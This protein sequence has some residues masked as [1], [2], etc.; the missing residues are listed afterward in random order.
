MSINPPLSRRDFLK[1]GGLALGSLAFSPFKDLGQQPDSS[2]RNPEELHPVYTNLTSQFYLDGR[3]LGRNEISESNFVIPDFARTGIENLS[4]TGNVVVDIY[5]KPSSRDPS[6]RTYQAV[7]I[8]IP[9]SDPDA[10][11]DIFHVGNSESSD[12][13]VAFPDGRVFHDSSGR[14][15]KEYENSLLNQE[16]YT[17]TFY[18]PR[19]D[20]IYTIKQ[21]DDYP[22]RFEGE[23][24]NMTEPRGN[25]GQRTT[26]S[27]LFYSDQF[28]AISATNDKLRKIAFNKR[29]FEVNRLEYNAKKNEWVEKPVIL[30]GSLWHNRLKGLVGSLFKDKSDIDISNVEPI[31]NELISG[32]N[33]PN[34]KTERELFDSIFSSL[35]LKESDKK[36][37][38]KYKDYF[39][40]MIEKKDRI[41]ALSTLES[42][43]IKHPGYLNNL[44]IDQIAQLLELLCFKKYFV[45][46][47]NYTSDLF[48]ASVTSLLM[49]YDVVDQG[50]LLLSPERAGWIVN[51]DT[52]KVKKATTDKEIKENIEVIESNLF[53]GDNALFYGLSEVKRDTPLLFGL[54]EKC[55]DS[56]TNETYTRYRIVE[57]NRTNRTT[58]T[59]SEFRN[60]DP[61]LKYVYKPT[62]NFFDIFRNDKEP[63]DLNDLAVVGIPI[64]SSDDVIS[65]EINAACVITPSVCYQRPSDVNQNFQPKF[66]LLYRRA[67][68]PYIQGGTL[69]TRAFFFE[70]NL[71]QE[72]IRNMSGNNQ[73]LQPNNNEWFNDITFLYYQIRGRN[74]FSNVTLGAMPDLI[75]KITKAT[76]NYVG[77]DGQWDYK[78]IAEIEPEYRSQWLDFLK[79]DKT[80]VAVVAMEETPVMKGNL[81]GV[82]LL[83]N[84][85]VNGNISNLQKTDI[86]LPLG[87][88]LA[89]ERVVF[90]GD[91]PY[92]VVKRFNPNSINPE[93]FAVPLQYLF[94]DQ[95]PTLQQHILILLAEIGLTYVSIYNP[96]VR[97]AGQSL[98]KQI[99]MTLLKGIMTLGP[100]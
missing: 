81:E 13:W 88:Y 50:G 60:D 74:M 39:S 61:L 17:E 45:A 38:N 75:K 92:A 68:D 64:T 99:V 72:V 65:S 19:T 80:S 26:I 71:L 70:D 43:T 69:N 22:Q 63:I 18:D 16:T 24:L 27:E 23:F 10:K 14:L 54:T 12:L 48:R 55:T 7:Q 35:N 77:T 84:L 79:P 47:F 73:L 29:R 49:P 20:A 8:R 95:A 98:V 87:D 37:A 25:Q 21:S 83:N 2:F 28:H 53:W 58:K 96:I 6:Q 11:G 78:N 89:V 1:L 62:P 40:N 36:K 4:Q 82:S 46:D 100:K 44:N 31:I 57:Y 15:S 94:L 67:D 90:D 91:S 97:A 76:I 66:A 3:L 33:N 56:N 86:R 34:N 93:V 41:N 85:L 30:P 5:T 52:R 32:Q 42:L 51:Y 9:N 59:V